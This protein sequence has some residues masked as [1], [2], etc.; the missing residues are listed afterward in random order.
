[1]EFSGQ[2][3][4]LGIEYD[5]AGFSGWQLQDGPRTVQEELERALASV[6]G[7]PIRV[8]VAGRT[9]AGVHAVCQVV[10]FDSPVVRPE[11]AWVRGSNRFLPR[12]VS[13]LWARAVPQDFHARFSATG[14]SYRY[15]ILNR[16]ERPALAANR[17]TWVPQLLDHLAMQGAANRLLGTHDFSAF[18]AA[19]CQAKNP[20]RSL[21][22][23][24]IERRGDLLIAT[25]EANAFLHHMVRN[26]MGT[27]LFVGR[28][29]RPADWVAEV[30]ASRDRRLAGT[31]A[32]ADGLY[33]LRAAYPD[34]YAL[35][36]CSDVLFGA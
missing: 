34:E 32:P 23:L 11:I 10:H 18:R 29:E 12:D 14:R 1:M 6:A 31:T 4:A 8:S 9:D 33:F 28:G 13:V 36:V 15:L 20:V 22:R 27:L 19:G 16:R 30:L 26:L 3:W 2:R 24:T 35:P 17:A 25:V 7:Q 21:R 5:G